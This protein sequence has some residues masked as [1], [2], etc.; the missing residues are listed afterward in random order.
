MKINK[1]IAGILA[2]AMLI[3]FS[4][5]KQQEARPV[6]KIINQAVFA[7]GHLEQ[8]DEYVVAATADGTIQQ[9]N[10]REGDNIRAAQIL[11]HIKSEVPATQLQ[12]A[13]VLYDNARL[14]ATPAAPQLSQI[15][16]QIGLAQTQL[17][18]DKVN[19]QRYVDLRSKNSVSP[20]ELE[21]A[22]LQYKAAQNNLQVLE[23]N[24][25]QARDALLLNADR[26]REQLKTQQ[27]ILEDYNIRADKEGVVLNVFKKKGELV[28]KGEV[29]AR[30]G[31]GKHLLKLFIAEEDIT[32]LSVGQEAVVQMN[33]YPDTVFRASITKILP[34]FDQSEQSYIAEAI[35]QNPPPLLLSGTQL[36]ANIKQQG[37]QKVLVIPS[38]SVVR[39]RFVQLKNG[40]ERAITTG[41]K[42]GAYI[43]VKA[44]LTEND[45]LLLPA[46][47]EK[48]EGMTIPGTE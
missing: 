28:R 9:L 20:Q 35:F 17:L 7:S 39:G 32:K 46:G 5:N 16:V 47:A 10:M 11:V 40:E 6:Y 31:S 8:E 23:K 36:Q 37:T 27:A 26:S 29:I 44:G 43:E 3:L 30:I 22:E 24:Y 19:Y 21:K 12:E 18:Q 1:R 15:Q 48:T 42:L 4:C 25:Q 34:A 41:M 38:S 33:N 14:N 45:I 2:V 13:K